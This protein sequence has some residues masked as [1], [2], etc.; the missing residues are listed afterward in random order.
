[1]Q[2]GAGK[3]CRS[4][5]APTIIITATYFGPVEEGEKAIRLLS[6]EPCVVVLPLNFICCDHSFR[7][8]KINCR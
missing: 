5:K 3:C 6:E 1:M 8:V 7:I 4:N 2:T